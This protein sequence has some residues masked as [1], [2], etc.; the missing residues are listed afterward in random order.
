MPV[1]IPV[2]ET[3][4]PTTIVDAEAAGTKVLPD[5]VTPVL[6]TVLTDETV[7][8]VAIPVPETVWFATIEV[9]EV[10][11]VSTLLSNVVVPVVAAELPLVTAV[12]R[13]TLVKAIETLPLAVAA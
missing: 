11:A 2:P 3:E 1:V 5:V 9:V 7:V 8:P 13:V 12:S 10:N 4:L 6:V